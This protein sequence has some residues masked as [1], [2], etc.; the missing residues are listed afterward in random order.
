MQSQ[1]KTVLS[2]SY[3]TISRCLFNFNWDIVMHKIILAVLISIFSIIVFNKFAIA[4]NGFNL[5]NTSVDKALIVSGGP[6]K[7]G[8]PS[9][10][11][12]TFISATDVDF[13]DLTDRVLGI[14]YHG[15]VKAYPV[16]IL[17]FHEIVNDNFREKPVAVT[18]CPLCGSGIA[19]LTMINGKKHR[20]GVSGLLYNSDVLLYDRETESLWS[21]IMSTAISGPL[22]GRRLDMLT[23]T[24]T[25]WQDWR[26][27]YPDT[28]VLSTNTGYSFDYN[29]NPYIGYELDKR[30]WFPVK[31]QDDSRHPKSLIIGIEINGQFKAYPFSELEQSKTKIADTF[32]GQELM[33][34]YSKQ[35]Q[36]ARITDKQGNEL[37]TITTFWFAW[38]AFHPKGS[39]FTAE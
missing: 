32:S 30:I 28:L 9:I 4:N 12:P 25:S 2:V 39:V 13:L 7:D 14:N 36:S 18:F 1:Q 31:S 5:S 23:L 16:K 19:Y 37:P 3:R 11:N 24:H 38:H 17:N 20:F 34:H 6:A 22:L 35:H 8:I 15:I 21:Q 29:S 26:Q 33:V 10:D 27:R